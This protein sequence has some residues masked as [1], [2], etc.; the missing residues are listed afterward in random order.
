MPPIEP[1]RKPRP[2]SCRLHRS[3]GAV[4]Y[5][6]EGEE[7]WPPPP[8]LVEALLPAVTAVV[9]GVLVVV[10]LVVGG[11]VLVVVGRLLDLVLRHR[12]VDLAVVVVDARH[13]AR[14]D[15]ALLAE[16]P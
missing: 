2:L 6:R 5:T 1:G 14:R 12:D 4:R 9:A 16:D 13:D 8:L 10:R 7:V 3:S 15:Q 11:H